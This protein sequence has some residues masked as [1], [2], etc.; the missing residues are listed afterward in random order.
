MAGYDT[1]DYSPSLRQVKRIVEAYQR[2]LKSQSRTQPKA[3]RDRELFLGDL[4]TCLD[5][6]VTGLRESLRTDRVRVNL[7]ISSEDISFY[8]DQFGPRLQ[9]MSHKV[10]TEFAKRKAANLKRKL[11]SAPQPGPSSAEASSHVDDSDDDEVGGAGDHDD[12]T[13]PE[14]VDKSRKEKRTDMI[15]VRMPRNVFMSPELISSLDRCKASDYSVMR[16]FAQLFKQFET[17][18][19]KRI[20]LD[21]FVLSR[22]SIRVARIEQRSVIAETEK[23]KFRMNMPLRLAFGW[24]G[25]MLKDMMNLKHEMQAMVLSGAPGYIEGKLIDVIELRDEDGNPTSTGEAQAEAIF[26][27]VVNWGA[28]DN[29]VVFNFDTTASNTGPYS[30]SC[31]RF[32]LFLN[33][34][35][36]YCACRH[37]VFDLIAKNTFHKIVGYDPSPDVAMFKKM[38]EVWGNINTSGS[39]LMF[40]ID[41]KEDLIELFTN[42]LTKKNVNGELFVRKDYRELCEISL[43]MLGGKLPEDKQMRWRP[44]GASH[45][46]RFMAF[47]ICGFKI[48]AFSHLPEVRQKVFSKKVK[49][50]LIFDEEA[51]QK[52]WR[53]GNFAVKFYVPQFLLATLGRDAP[54]NDLNLYK[55]L[56]QYREVDRELADIALDTLSRHKWYL[57]EYVVL[58]SL[59]SDI[60][61]EEEKAKIVDRLNTLPRDSVPSLGHPTFPVVTEDTELWDLVTPKSWQFFDIVKSDPVWL[62]Q[63]VSEW[64]QDP[65]YME[66]KDFVSTVKVVS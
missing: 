13:D 58:F 20:K 43:V 35:V 47:G 32:N 7:G 65:D 52:L 37:H 30:G 61:S 49:K 66:I 41:D 10:D 26:I 25:K 62:T 53:W 4:K 2:L 27:A 5:I 33:R 22:S 44:P 6:G 40:D 11:S 3:I 16:T 45:K 34:P 19:G 12:N 56:L 42:I 18:D 1:V 15:T 63:P 31:I 36:L 8:D 38:K 17:D 54:S 46:A 60:T 48:L 51:L 50:Q 57:T 59:F 9:A 21:E 29:I 28:A 64:D 39:F 14:Y 55:S 24:D 23:A